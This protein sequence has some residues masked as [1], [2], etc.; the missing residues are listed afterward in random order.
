MPMHPSISPSPAAIRPFQ[1]LP[2]ERVATRVI[3]QKQREKYSQG[4]SVNAKSAMMGERMVA[5]MTEKKVPRNEAV[6][7]TARA[8]LDSPFSVM[9]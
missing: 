6:I 1:I 9:G 4:P 3:A 7:P 5:S 2:F 8:L